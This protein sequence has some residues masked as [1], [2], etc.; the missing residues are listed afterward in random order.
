MQV[1][2]IVSLTP[3]VFNRYS[4]NNAL[5][6]EPIKPELKMIRNDLSLL[7]FD[8]VSNI[9]MSCKMSAGRQLIEAIKYPNIIR[10]YVCVQQNTTAP[11]V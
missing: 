2:N 5:K 7:S 8:V 9:K 3:K 6:S 11:I 4:A 1:K 10:I